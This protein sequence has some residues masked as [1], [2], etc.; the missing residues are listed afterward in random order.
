VGSG[1]EHYQLRGSAAE[2]YERYLV[3]VVTSQWARDPVPESS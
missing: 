3:P 1:V 2:L